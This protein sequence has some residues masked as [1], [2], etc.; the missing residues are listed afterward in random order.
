MP[1]APPRHHLPGHGLAK[2]SQQRL[3]NVR[4]GQ[5]Y[6]APWRRLRDW[7]IGNNPLCAACSTED[8]PVSA[9]DVDH[10]VPV[11]QA[12]DRRLDPTNLQSLCRS[13]HG[14]KTYGETLGKARDTTP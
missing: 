2:Q 8:W 11:V 4:S 6:D 12:P 10:I 5:T 7:W 9:T 13:C 1:A 14:R 3:R